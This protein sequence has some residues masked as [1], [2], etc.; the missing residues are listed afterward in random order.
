MKNERVPSVFIV[1]CSRGGTTL[2]Q[3]IIAK[4]SAFVAFPESN[5]LYQPLGD[6]DYRRYGSLIGRRAIPRQIMWRIV[7]RIG[8]TGYYPRKLFLK[9]LLPERARLKYL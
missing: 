9:F 6:I 5:I 1:G 7:N 3:S 2:L 8:F 4:Q